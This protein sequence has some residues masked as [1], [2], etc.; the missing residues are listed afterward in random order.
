M[1]DASGQR[2]LFGVPRDLKLENRWTTTRQN[3]LIDAYRTGCE[4]PYKNNR[5]MLDGTPKSWGE[6]ELKELLKKGKSN[7]FRSLDDRRE[8]R[9]SLE[10]RDPRNEGGARRMEQILSKDKSQSMSQVH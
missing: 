1:R 7:S 8:I 5:W 10:N 6:R 9:E 3:S 4:A 2:Q